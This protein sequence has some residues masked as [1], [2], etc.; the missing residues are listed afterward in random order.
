MLSEFSWCTTWPSAS[1]GENVDA[2][3]C[4]YGKSLNYK[5]IY[6]GSVFKGYC[7]DCTMCLQRHLS[8]TNQLDQLKWK[9][10]YCYRT[11]TLHIVTYIEKVIWPYCWDVTCVYVIRL[12]QDEPLVS[13][14]EFT[15]AWHFS[16]LKFVLFWVLCT[17]DRSHCTPESQTELSA[18]V[19]HC[20]WCRRQ[21]L[22]RK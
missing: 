13:N 17:M 3:K 14:L 22:T 4:L 20:G 2:C 12:R 18:V 6:R 8:S 9:L 21:V 16:V 19:V 11:Q 7:R 1:A 10:H 5:S 15:L